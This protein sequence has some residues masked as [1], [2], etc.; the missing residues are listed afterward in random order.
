LLLK[1]AV[2]IAVPSVPAPQAS[3]HSSA[4]NAKILEDLAAEKMAVAGDD[5]TQYFED[6]P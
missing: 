5:H 6:A 3:Q 2:L 4:Q 1:I